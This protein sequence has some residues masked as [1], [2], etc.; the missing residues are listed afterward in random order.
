MAISLKEFGFVDAFAAR[1][2]RGK[3]ATV[4]SSLSCWSALLS[5]RSAAFLQRL[6]LSSLFREPLGRAPAPARLTRHCEAF[7]CHDRL[8]QLCPLVTELLK[9]VVHV[10]GSILFAF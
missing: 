7:Y 8:L 2:D 9:N 6:L 5:G 10:H 3:S 4:G 1:P